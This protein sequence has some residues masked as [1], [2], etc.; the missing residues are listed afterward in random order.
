MQRDAASALVGIG[1]M[2][3]TGA[4]FAVLDTSAKL[5]AASVPIIM[6][7]SIR[8]LLQALISTAVLAP[9]HGRGLLRVR[10]PWLQAVRGSLLAASTVLAMQGLKI[11]P[12]GEFTAIVMITPMVVT[13]LAVT[14]LKEKVSLVHWLFVAGGFAGAL[15]IVRPGAGQGLGWGALY[16]LG[17]M[18]CSSAFQLLSN[19]LGRTENPAT[20]HFWSAWFGAAMGALALPFFWAHVDSP[21][22]WSVMLLMGTMGAGGHFALAQ[23][24]QKAPAS[25]LMPYMYVHVGFAVLGGWL[26]FGHV[27]DGVAFLGIALIVACGIASAWWGARHSRAVAA[28]PET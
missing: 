12:V 25:I 16:G 23:A 18:A 27:P 9:V 5:V 17:C 15:V 14:V 21:L 4:C 28:M 6:A 8:Y 24:H 11:M 2:V 1:Y 13:I 3:L 22:L 10:H 19:H 7:A 26:V 20:T